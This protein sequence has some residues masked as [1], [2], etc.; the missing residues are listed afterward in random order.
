MLSRE[1]SITIILLL[2]FQLNVITSP[3]RYTAINY[4]YS[5]ITIKINE[6]GNNINVYSDYED[7]KSKIGG[8]DPTHDFIRPNEIHINGINQSSINYKY[9]FNKTENIIKLIWNN[10]Y[11]YSIAYLFRE[12]KKIAEI[13][14]SNFNARDT[15]YMEFLFYNCISLTS[16]NFTN[17]YT[18]KIKN[19]HYLFYNC[20]SLKE[21]DLSNFVTNSVEKMSGMFYNCIS[22]SSLNLSNFNTSQVSSMYNMFKNCSSL[23][24]LDISSLK[25]PN[26]NHTY[27]MFNY[28][29]LLTSL[30]LS[31]FK[32][33][34]YIQV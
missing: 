34:K 9:N 24:K 30:D 27:Y 28:C 14:L 23:K 19:M 1:R 21:I 5:Y 33:K 32:S 11:I 3:N 12:C 7:G 29:P 18:P 13:D 20:I 10:D 22:L 31:N 6:A 17:F 26:L 4:Y 25:I 8:P 2:I 15:S 16:I